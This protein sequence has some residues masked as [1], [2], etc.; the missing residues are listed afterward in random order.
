MRVLL[1]TNMLLRAVQI[2]HPLFPETTQAISI[3]VRRNDAL[4]FSAQNVIEFWNVATRPI[5]SNGFGLSPQEVLNEIAGFEKLFSLLPDVPEIYTEWK[6]VVATHNVQGVKVH[7]ARLVAIM[8]VYSL[9]SLLTFNS[10]DFARFSNIT[11]IH[12]SFIS[13]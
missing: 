13:P 10:S 5:L 11:A 6:R 8:T 9:D 2:N 7:D 12:P 1:D 4:L 3:L